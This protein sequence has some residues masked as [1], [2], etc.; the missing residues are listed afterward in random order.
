MDIGRVDILRVAVIMQVL[1]HLPTTKPQPLRC[2]EWNVTELILAYC[3]FPL[4]RV[5]VVEGEIQRDG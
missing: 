4:L 2:V 5:M 3:Y 1:K